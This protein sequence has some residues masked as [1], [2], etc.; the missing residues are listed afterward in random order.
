MSRYVYSIVRCLPDP[1]TGEFVNIGAVAGDPVS[2]RWAIRQLSNTERIRRFAGGLALEAATSCLLAIGE[3]ID[4]NQAALLEDEVEPLD[5]D[6]LAKLHRDHRNVI[7]F[8]EPA[9]ILANDPQEALAFVFDHLITDPVTPSKEL[10]VTKYDL[11]RTL[12]E[13]FK[14]AAIAEGLIR[15]K[16]EIF[17]GARVHTPIDFAIANGRV[18]QLAQT[19]SFRLAQ[20]E[21]VPMKVKAWGYALER[22]RSGEEARVIDSDGRMSTIGPDVD[23]QVVIAPP[24]TPQQTDAFEEAQQVFQ[25]LSAEVH[26]LAEVSAVTTRAAELAQTLR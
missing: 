8:S 3:E 13:A 14:R 4:Q 2:G 5:E 9:P 12:R 15:S 6:W 20:V 18:V 25:N 10:H 11:R 17:V 19:W 21:D 7:Q 1:R 23:L 16:V 22:L 24:Q 26:D